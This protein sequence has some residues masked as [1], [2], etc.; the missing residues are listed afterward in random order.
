MYI[1]TTKPGFWEKCGVWN[2]GRILEYE[3]KNLQ[4]RILFNV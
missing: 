1:E 2:A 4:K 3:K